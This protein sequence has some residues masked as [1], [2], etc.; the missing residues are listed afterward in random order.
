MGNSDDLN[1]NERDFAL[2]V[3]IRDY[4]SLSKLDA[5]IQDVEKMR[6]WLIHEKG[7]NLPEENIFEPLKD[8][9]DKYAGN[10][11]DEDMRTIRN[12]AKSLKN[13][14]G[15]LYLYFTGH[16]LSA[17]AR[18]VHFCLPDWK[19]VGN[20]DSVVTASSYIDSVINCDL[21]EEVYFFM[22]SCRTRIIGSNIKASSRPITDDIMDGQTH[23]R[24]F[25]IGFAARDGH[26]A[27]YYEELGDEPPGCSHFTEALVRGLF[28]EAANE[29]GGVELS[30]LI[31]YIE[32]HTPKIASENRHKV[33]NPDIT[34]NR[35]NRV[36]L[37]KMRPMVHLRLKLETDFE[38]PLFL[39]GNGKLRKIDPK[40]GSLFEWEL[41]SG[42]LYMIKEDH[43]GR[44]HWKGRLYAA[45]EPTDVII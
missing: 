29:D 20:I 1:K 2:L 8:G 36:I 21:F 27:Y 32:E 34:V 7:G 45:E 18:D 22:D 25:L 15:K 42:I 19:Q 5:A 11:I 26:A 16:G 41:P 31:S 38:H 30:R 9:S 17:G 14:A 37:G 35:I 24:G 40:A 10:R 43:V 44:E 28:G 12:Q 23:H 4:H 6:K 3:G 33:Q 39:I 13:K